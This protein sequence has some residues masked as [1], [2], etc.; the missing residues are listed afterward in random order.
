MDNR[1]LM[2]LIADFLRQCICKFHTAH[3]LIE[4]VVDIFFLHGWQQ[5][6]LNRLMHVTHNHLPRNDLIVLADVFISYYYLLN[7]QQLV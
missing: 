1:I 2:E 4:D 5:F 6:D 3:N 7:R